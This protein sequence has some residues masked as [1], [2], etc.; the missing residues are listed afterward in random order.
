MEEPCLPAIEQA[1]VGCGQALAGE[2][3]VCPIGFKGGADGESEDP[4]GER[5]VIDAARWAIGGRRIQFCFDHPAKV[6]SDG[7]GECAAVGIFQNEHAGFCWQGGEIERCRIFGCCG[8]IDAERDFRAGKQVGVPGR[9]NQRGALRPCD[10]CRH[11]GAMRA[12][13]LMP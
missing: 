7:K 5:T 8:H 13:W 12:G 6:C 3:Q 2:L 1:T 11:A 10:C 4:A 9:K